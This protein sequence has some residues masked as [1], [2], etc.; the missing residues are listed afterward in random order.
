[1]TKRLPRLAASLLLFTTLCLP[2]VTIAQMDDPPPN[3]G[4]DPTSCSKPGFAAPSGQTG[5][6]LLARNR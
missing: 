1:V 2:S 6:A 5:A 3:C 4:A